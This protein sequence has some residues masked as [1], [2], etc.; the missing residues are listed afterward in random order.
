MVV[1]ISLDILQLPCGNEILDA[2]QSMGVQIY[3]KKYDVPHIITWKRT[4]TKI[5]DNEMK[6]FVPSETVYLFE[7]PFVLRFMDVEAFVSLITDKL[8]EKEV[9]HMAKKFSGRRIILL[10]N[11]LPEYYRSKRMLVKKSFEQCIRNGSLANVSVNSTP[12]SQSVIESQILM[13]NDAYKCHTME[14]SKN[15]SLADW[16]VS[17][18]REIAVRPYE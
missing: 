8:L 12:I 4:I 11:G 7:E 6:A 13:L 10:I 18:T 2:L 14:I 15:E 5:Y 9:S 16:L 1:E 17:Y 3:S